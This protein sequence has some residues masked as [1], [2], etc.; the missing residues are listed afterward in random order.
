MGYSELKCSYFLKNTYFCLPKAL[1]YPRASKHLNT[2]FTSS[3]LSRFLQ[4]DFPIT[5]SNTI[6]GSNSASPQTTWP[7]WSFSDA[8][9]VSTATVFGLQTCSDILTASFHCLQHCAEATVQI[10]RECH[11]FSDMYDT[12][13]HVW[14]C[15]CGFGSLTQSGL[16]IWFQAKKQINHLFFSFIRGGGT[17]ANVGH[18]EEKLKRLW[19]WSRSFLLFVCL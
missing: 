4:S 12:L 2:Y 17:F 9:V 7:C 15:N 13:I 19:C 16:C 3:D 1:C 11:T 18:L 8:P 10:Q 14:K 6:T 5:H